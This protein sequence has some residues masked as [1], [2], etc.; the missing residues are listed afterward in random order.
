MS[1]LRT[2]GNFIMSRR[3]LVEMK[4][5]NPFWG[6]SLTYPS[7]DLILIMFLCFSSGQRQDGDLLVARRVRKY[8]LSAGTGCSASGQWPNSSQW[9]T[10]FPTPAT[11]TPNLVL[12]QRF[13]LWWPHSYCYGGDGKRCGRWRSATSDYLRHYHQCNTAH[14]DHRCCYWHHP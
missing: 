9:S 8:S 11:R 10:S 7:W 5:S 6:R 4:V 14:D 1:I 12:W 13:F 2:F 3:G